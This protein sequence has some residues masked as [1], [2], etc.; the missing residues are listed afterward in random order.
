M[1]DELM[2]EF[3]E[4]LA[5][6]AIAILWDMKP[7]IENF[8]LNDLVPAFQDGVGAA[9][10]FF[11]DLAY[12]IKGPEM[13]PAIASA[14]PPVLPKS[15]YAKQFNIERM[16]DSVR[17]ASNAYH[18][19]SSNPEKQKA[20][21]QSMVFAARF[22]NEAKALLV[23]NPDNLTVSLKDYA[24]LFALAEEATRFRNVNNLNE[25]LR[26]QHN[27][28]GTSLL[29]DLSSIVGHEINPDSPVGPVEAV[30]FR[31][32]L[33]AMPTRTPMPIAD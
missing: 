22:V 30:Q 26:I 32:D 25:V 7:Y 15:D 33:Y 31:I 16:T 27:L 2:N 23:Y 10:R 17:N 11:D 24:N 4:S 14:L 28:F 12:S 20:F 5:A 6:L 8:I 1:T 19:D 13:S 9:A 21:V 3:E 18:R 29:S